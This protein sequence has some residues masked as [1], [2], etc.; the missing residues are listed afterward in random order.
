MLSINAITEGVSTVAP[1]YNVKRIEL[2]G[3]YANNKQTNKSDVDLLVEFNQD[4][5]SL[6]TLS[7]LRQKIEECLGV[8]VDLLHAPLPA[9]AFFDTGSPVLIY[10]A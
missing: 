1:S 9:N 2:F 7:S 3:S 6:L 10:E 5:V 8:P 4:A